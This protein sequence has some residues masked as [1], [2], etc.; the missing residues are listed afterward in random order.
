[1]PEPPIEPPVIEDD[2]SEDV[3][4]PTDGSQAESEAPANEPPT[5]E[6][7]TP[8]PPVADPPADEPPA[9]APEGADEPPA[10]DPGIF[11]PPTRDPEPEVVPDPAD[12]P[13]ATEPETDPLDGIFGGAASPFDMVDPEA[14]AAE[15]AASDETAPGNNVTPEED[16]AAGEEAD[17]EEADSAL[18]DDLFGTSRPS[19]LAEADPTPR[20]DAA[21]LWTDAS[22]RFSCEAQ[23]VE[24]TADG[25]VLLRVSDGAEILIRYRRLSDADLRYLRDRIDAAGRPGEQGAGDLVASRG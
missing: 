1:M 15:P 22:G 23:F 25:V 2:G 21:R 7:P 12:E 4:P 18:D 6:S 3:A 5:D 24:A 16:A 13:P 20:N 14:G 9:E 19:E 8:E 17:D 10:I 11:D